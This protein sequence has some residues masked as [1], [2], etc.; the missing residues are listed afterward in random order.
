MEPGVWLP[1]SIRWMITTDLPACQ[2]IERDA[3]DE[4][5]YL[6]PWAIKDFVEQLENINC[7]GQIAEVTQDGNQVIGGFM[8]FE[9][10]RARLVLTRLTVHPAVRRAGIAS[11]LLAYL[12]S[13]IS[14]NRYREAIC[15]VSE[16][17]LDLQMFLKTLGWTATKVLG[18]Y[19]G[20]DDGIRFKFWLQE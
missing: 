12:V 3:A 15:D 4:D 5:N 6:E 19:K 16:R 20:D 1:C 14:P 2:Q 9:R 18:R 8:L 11:Q 10:E 17:S 13:K 7:I